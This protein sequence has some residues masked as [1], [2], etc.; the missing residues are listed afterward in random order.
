MPNT[1]WHNGLRRRTPADT[2]HHR[3]T[4]LTTDTAAPA[5]PDLI[6]RLT[7]SALSPEEREE[8]MNHV[9]T[10]APGIDDDIA[11]RVLYLTVGALTAHGNVDS[12][13][14]A[15]DAIITTA[16]AAKEKWA[17]AYLRAAEGRRYE[18]YR[19]TYN[20]AVSLQMSPANALRL[21]HDLDADTAREAVSH[22]K[23]TTPK[24]TETT[25]STDD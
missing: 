7:S 5:A 19:D 3:E 12:G 18:P 8:L 25:E 24:T 15:V 16:A 9:R 21:A 11:T 17:V 6:D 20:K 23:K 22:L 14:A 13:Q 10:A 1:I 2:H 4:T